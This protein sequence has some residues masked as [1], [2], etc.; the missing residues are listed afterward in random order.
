MAVVP[1]AYD[2][3]GSDG[4]SISIARTSTPSVELEDARR[5]VAA[6]ASSLST[7]AAVAVAPLSTRAP[8]PSPLG[9]PV[10]RPA[11]SGGASAR[12]RDCKTECASW[13]KRTRPPRARPQRFEMDLTRRE[14]L[15][16]RRARAANGVE[17]RV[18]AVC[19]EG[20]YPHKDYHVNQDCFVVAEKGCLTSAWGDIDED[21][22]ERE[23]RASVGE[24]LVG[25]FDGHGKHGEDCA[26]IARG[27]FVETLR[28]EVHGTEGRRPAR[29][30]NNGG[31]DDAYAQTFD[32]VNAIVC[33]TM[34][35]EASF[36][37]STAITALFGEDGKVRIG[38]V[39]DSRCVVGIDLDGSSSS[40]SSNP[41]SAT[42][43]RHTKSWVVRD[44]THDQTCF[45]A[46]ERKRM[47]VEAQSPMMFATIGMV[48]GETEQ[49]E[50]FGDGE[51]GSDDE[52]CDDPPRV[53]M[54]GYRFPGCAF[55]RSIGDTVGKALGVS[56]IPEMSAFDLNEEPNARCIIVASDGVFEFMSS[57]ETMAIAERFYDDGK[58]DACERAAH[59]IVRTAYT[60]WQEQDE[61]ADD[62]TA[63]VAFFYPETLGT[64]TATITV[65]EALDEQLEKLLL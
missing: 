65:N 46:D 31:L 15:S 38:N 6:N 4:R 29:H 52:Y 40:S 11:S 20:C 30:I 25:V 18:A 58:A 64:S 13:T 50:D 17:V 42:G 51:P 1:S 16:E 14:V 19:Q 57:A 39:G 33:K 61:R 10:T 3:V 37:G 44:L 34:G 28:E 45:R 48:L 41:S 5:A 43:N 2:P 59:A 55:T 36:S 21:G 12:L 8:T 23:T 49:H 7:R 27:T 24:L 35:E 22:E 26:Q 47:K 32:K 56:A 62:V 54:A 53:F 63:V 60:R 9:A